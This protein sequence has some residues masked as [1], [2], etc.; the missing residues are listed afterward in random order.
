MTRQRLDKLLSRKVRPDRFD[1]ITLKFFIMSQENLADKPK[2]RFLRFVEETGRMLKECRMWPLY[3][4]NPYEAAVMMCMLT[5]DPLTAY[6]DIWELSYKG[7][8]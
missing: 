7:E 1:L 6:S 2:H 4:V 5:D 8:I 3:P